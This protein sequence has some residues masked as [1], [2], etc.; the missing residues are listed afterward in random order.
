MRQDGG[1]KGATQ[2]QFLKKVA[3]I[4]KNLLGVA[5]R[6]SNDKTIQDKQNKN[7]QGL[8]KH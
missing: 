8:F 7:E 3:L 1:T 2:T 6:K 5:R 4:V